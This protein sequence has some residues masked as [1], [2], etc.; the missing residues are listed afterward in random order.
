MIRTGEFVP[1]LAIPTWA[2]LEGY[3][4]A[5]VPYCKSRKARE[6][7][8]TSTKVQTEEETYENNK[9]DRQAAFTLVPRSNPNIIRL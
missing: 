4:V 9:N 5:S 7:R 3:T 1:L 6:K 2:T 8:S